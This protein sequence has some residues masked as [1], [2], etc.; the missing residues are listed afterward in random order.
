MKRSCFIL[1]YRNLQKLCLSLVL[2][3]VATLGARAQQVVTTPKAPQPPQPAQPQPDTLVVKSGRR[4]S[5]QIVTLVHRVNGFKALLLLRRS[6]QMIATVDDKLMTSTD[7]VTS[8]TAGF[9]LGDGKSVV[10]RLSQ[11]EAE[12]EAQTPLAWSYTMQTPPGFSG[13]GTPRPEQ[14]EFVVVENSGKQF[15]AKYVG[16]DGGSGLSLFQIPGLNVP[17]SRDASEEKLAIG[18]RVRLFAPARIATTVSTTEP[19]TV[20]VSV[21]EI[22]GKITEITRTSTGKIAHLTVSAP[23]LS[24]AIV[25]GVTLNDGGE[26]IGIV[27]TSNAGQARLVPVA[28]VRRAAE[29]VL[30]RKAS[31]PRPW[32]GVRGEAVATTPFQ[33]FYSIGWTETEVAKLKEIQ[34]GILLTSVAPG[35]PAA[36]ADLRPGDVIVR[37]NDF[38]VKSAEDFSFFLNE[39]GSGATVNFTFFRGQAPKAPLGFSPA[40]PPM[41]PFPP[42]P[43]PASSPSPSLMPPGALSSLLKPLEV[44]VKMGETLN[45]A[46]A[47]RLAQAYSVGGQRPNTTPLIT[48]GLETV[49]LSTKAAAHLGARSGLLVVFIEPE[50]AAARAGLR[51]FD[52]IE[53]VEGK[54]LG[55]T[56]LA[57]ALP[58]GNP[59]KLS[60]GVVRDHQ[61]VEITLQQKN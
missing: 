58:V 59:Q 50:S 51:V 55:R 36:L 24:P 44:S 19:S 31:V 17:V 7:A 9:A 47:M 52:V 56:P 23:N 22:E 53:S 39:A 26:T 38:D 15:T 27:E 21:G 4:Q 8:I 54:P 6:G 12:A 57:G 40:M 13:R 41:P 34:K 30:A 28:A 18:Q 35:T 25:G 3:G 60:L 46:G 32:L 45:P 37:V 1:L 48:R 61:K 42:T 43:R 14:P 49:M 5:P 11:A 16:L 33:S 29:R 20:S 10:A 2:V